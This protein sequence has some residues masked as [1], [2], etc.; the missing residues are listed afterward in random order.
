MTSSDAQSW[1]LREIDNPLF[2]NS[3]TFGD[4]F[5]AVGYKFGISTDPTGISSEPTITHVSLGYS[6]SSYSYSYSYT[7][8]ADSLSFASF[9]SVHSAPNSQLPYESVT[10]GNGLYVAIA[11]TYTP[12]A[13]GI[14]WSN[15]GVSW[16]AVNPPAANNWKSV[17]YGNGLFA[18][19][20]M[21]STEEMF[22]YG[23]C[24]SGTQ[25]LCSMTSSDGVTWLLSSAGQQPYISIAYGIYNSDPIFVAGAA[26][27][28]G[29]SGTCSM[30]GV[31]VCQGS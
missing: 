6:H 30:T 24:G 16:T 20:S 26:S 15:N 8:N 12:G 7:N 31:L 9:W 21:G 4:K 13:N 19:I 27:L 22:P 29:N 5:V 18:A 11:P 17:V 3:I 23:T 25:N 1:K 28:C 2:F 10:F 14:A